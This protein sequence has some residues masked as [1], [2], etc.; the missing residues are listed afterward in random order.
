MV[1]FKLWFKDCK[2]THM[3][4]III[5]KYTYIKHICLFYKKYNVDFSYVQ[6]KK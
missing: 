1:F 4:I 2:Y 5:I 6:K 3:S